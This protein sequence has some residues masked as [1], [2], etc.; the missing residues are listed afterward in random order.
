M[1]D[2]Q[3][4]QAPKALRGIGNYIDDRF[5][6]AKTAEKNLRK[7]F[8]NH[9]SFMLGEIA[10]Y[11]F[12]ILLLTGVF[13]T[14]WFNPSMSH[15]V[16]EGSYERLRGV[17]MSEAYASTLHITFDVRGGLLVRQIHHWAAL[18]FVASLVVHMLRVFFTGA[19]RKPREINWLIGVAIFSIAIV[20]GLFGYSLPDDLPSG[21]GVRIF[22]GVL[23]AIPVI[24][25]YL[26]FF[27][28]GG[29]FPGEA[30]IPRLYMLHILLLPGILL[31][32]IAAHFIILW[33]QKHTQYPGPRRTE[34]QVIGTPMF[35][36]FALKAGGFFFFTFAAITGLSAFVQI[37]PI[38][39]FGPFTP[40]SITSGLQPDWYMGFLEGSLRLFPDWFDFD[41]GGYAV[42][43][44]VLVPGLGFMGL[45]F[46]GLAIYPFLEA[47]ITGDKRAHNIADRPRNVPVRT[48]LGAAGITF[49]GVLW[50]AGS[51][52]ILS[53]TFQISLFAT[54]WI[55]RIAL[56]VGPILAFIITKR[57][58]LGLQRRDRAT[59]E[60]GYE[61]GTITQ[62]PGGEFIEVHK[63]SSPETVEVLQSAKYQGFRTVPPTVDA[64]GVESPAARGFLGK[65]RIR[66]A[67]WYTK[68]NVSFEDVVPHSALHG[69]QR[70]EEKAGQH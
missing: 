57:I 50:L 31:A 25:T 2:N 17:E 48:G 28:F 6:L 42:V 22:Q 7:V 38:H 44:G 15:T 59:L 30:I 5:H 11:S 46:G 35:P 37:N 64:N 3:A 70:T 67:H 34:K 61:S 52:D 33:Y 53:H 55:F 14:L 8:P 45:L 10:L 21:M 29:E 4:P 63:E 65:L 49:Y 26:S 62:L 68:D 9:W 16:Y 32:L 36:G 27:M 66:L 58:C 43:T 1:S 56:I 20:E 18:I 19:F 40:T 69:E 12:I 54:T 51:N 41:I 24:G 47:W 60:H 13:L 23:L 39:L